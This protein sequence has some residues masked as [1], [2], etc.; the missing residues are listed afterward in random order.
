MFKKALVGCIILHGVAFAAPAQKDPFIWLEDVYGAKSMDWVKSENAR[1]LA[2]LKA[3]PV[4]EKF[5]ADSLAIATAADRIAVPQQL[6]GQIY[7]FWQDKNH[8]RGIWR[9]TSLESYRT[10]APVWN[11]VIDLDQLAHDEHANHVWKGYDCFEPAEKDCLV[12]L[13]DGGEDAI[14]AREYDLGKNGFVSSGFSLPRSKMS[15]DWQDA[16]HLLVAT[17]W[18]D[19][20]S[21]TAS[22]YPFVVKS[23]ARG[24]S[25]AQ[26]KEIFRG[27]PKDVEVDVQALDD[28]DGHHEVFIKQG[29]DFFHS[30]YYRVGAD[31]VQKLDLPQKSDL[32]GLVRGQLI[33]RVN[34]DWQGVKVKAG[35]LIALD[36]THSAQ[37]AKIVFTPGPR[38]SLEEVM[39]T[40]HHLV[41]AIYDNVRGEAFVYSPDQ[42]WQAQKIAL[43][44]N[45]AV[46]L[47]SSSIRDDR[48]FASV[49]GYLTP[50]SVWLADATGVPPVVVKT[51]PAR[52]DASQDVVEQFFA[53]SSDGV[54][55]PY[56]IVHR[57]DMKLDGSTPTVLY[58]YGG[59]QVSMVP[60]YSAYVGKL[61]L[62]RG[63]AFVVANIRGG[64]E[65]G[66]AWHEAALKTKRQVA[67]DDFAAVARDLVARKIT[68][69]KHLGIQGGSNG[70]LLMGV[71]FTQHPEMWGATV[72]EVPLLDMERFEQIAAGASWVGEYG[73]MKVPA[74]RKNLEQISPY[75]HLRAGVKYPEPF[76]YTTTKDDRVGPQHARKFAA[77]MKSLGLPY[78][79]YEAIE[80][81]HSAGVNAD[82][83]ATEHAL[84][85]TYFTEKLMP[86]S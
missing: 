69:G 47:V 30:A 65:F 80:G 55:I 73:S 6:D 42:K 74:E 49:A 9:R 70:G 76:I 3:D 50:P 52:F 81:G 39:V 29:L 75:A 15:V 7:N 86:N 45:N 61:W 17:D 48:F 43:P 58:G 31:G 4:Y 63:G 20:K 21:M 83:V 79:Y 19:G 35:S 25:L 32:M 27:S 33:V 68:D 1:S 26:A 23:L 60:V 36:L 54:K 84:E 10:A 72:I 66:P 56:Y 85:M 82:E 34:E 64:G 71:E 5:H 28:G 37:A 77:K 11:K 40:Q 38:Q 44:E 24:Q 46:G 18:G 22:G 2:V 8:V 16:D 78:L 62:E 57:K 13:S 12:F 67:Y 41:A 14:T 59:F 51:S 53:P